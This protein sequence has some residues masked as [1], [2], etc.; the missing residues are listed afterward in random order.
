[1]KI[2]KTID[3]LEKEAGKLINEITDRL[4]T[5]ELQSWRWQESEVG[6]EYDRKTGKLQIAY[7]SLV[8]S[9]NE[10]KDL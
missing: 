1:M 5:H 2:H 3:I 4:D 9:I 10:L 6:K 7:D 8:D